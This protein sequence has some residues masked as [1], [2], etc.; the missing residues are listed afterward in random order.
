VT[1]ILASP[2]FG[3][4]WIY[5]WV[6]FGGAN[7]LMAGLSLMII[8]L[9][10]LDTKKGWMISGIPG[11]FMIVTTIAALGYASYQSLTKGFASNLPGNIVA[12]IIGV[13][14]I[15]AAL[16]MC[17]DIFMAFQRRRNT[18]NSKQEH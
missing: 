3:G 17:Y 15:I 4:T 7:Q 9:W 2:T 13:I 10:L 6:L 1:F 18:N 12:G 5:I 8:T 14:L 11:V 16:I